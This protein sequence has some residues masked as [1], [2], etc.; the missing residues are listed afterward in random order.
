[1]RSYVQITR[2]A[3]ALALVL[4][5][6][7]PAAEDPDRD[8]T[9][10]WILD[11]KQSDFRGLPTAPAPVLNITLP[12]AAIQCVESG[13]DGQAARTWVY[14]TGGTPG[15]FQI[16]DS[17]MSAMTKWE[18]AALITNTL[19]TGPQNYS[20]NDRWRLSR[21]HNLLTIR[22]QIQGPTVDTEA[23]LVYRSQNAKEP[24]ANKPGE[25]PAPSNGAA[26]P[27]DDITVP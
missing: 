27:S 17:H 4:V 22:R 13:P 18:G 8:F 23:L 19:V 25:T 14:P 24:A 9:G 16:G 2:A 6:R 12:P 7:L 5:P 1:M 3:V 26:A 10:V 21:D 11:E 20:V 15:K